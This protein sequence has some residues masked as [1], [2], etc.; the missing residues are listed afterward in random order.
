MLVQP[1]QADVG[2]AESRQV[3]TDADTAELRQMLVELRQMLIQL[4]QDR[5][6]CNCWVQADVGY[7]CTKT[8]VLVE[9]K[10]GRCVLTGLD[11]R[12]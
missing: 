5:Y 1:V 3:L 12:T 7:N 10:R 6:C 4:S 11:L 8:D 9:K 2:T